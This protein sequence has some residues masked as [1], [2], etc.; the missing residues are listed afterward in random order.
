[1]NE[2]IIAA[3]TLEKVEYLGHSISEKVYNRPKTW[4]E[5]SEMPQHLRVRYNCICSVNH[6]GK[7]LKD[8]LNQLTL[9]PKENP[10]E[11]WRHEDKVFK[12]VKKQ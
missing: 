8:I 4:S 5:P 9:T 3:Q 2:S 11:K 12:L 6:Y 1:M 7:F 10:M